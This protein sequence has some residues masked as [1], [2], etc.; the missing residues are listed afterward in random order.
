MLRDLP[1]REIAPDHRAHEVVGIHPRKLP[2]DDEPAVAQDGDALA[3]SEDLLEPVRDEE[4]CDARLAQRR[5]HAE[6]PVDLD[7]R[8][9]RRRLVHHDHARIERERLC[10]LDELLL[11]DRQAAGDA[12][13][14]EA[15][16]EPLEDRVGLLAHGTA[17]DAPAGA[18]RLAADEDVLDDG[19]VGEERRL[20]VDHG[21]PGVA[22][23]CGPVH[24]DLDPVDEQPPAV[25]RVHGGEDLHERRLAGTVLADE[26][27][28]L[29]G[30][31]VDRDVLER[32]DRSERLRDVL[33]RED[34]GARRRRRPV[35]R[36]HRP[37]STQMPLR[38]TTSFDVEA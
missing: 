9:R 32:M 34:R 5:G 19:E 38:I 16:P 25:R 13:G 14:V 31:E 15:N 2:G 29:A 11:R 22:G 23:I 3:Q 6:Q 24:R 37:R 4:D 28:R 8:Q 21:D 20:L 30:V 7:G 33:E 17:V 10:D 36:A 27:V 1:R 18:E 26:G 12:V 35:H